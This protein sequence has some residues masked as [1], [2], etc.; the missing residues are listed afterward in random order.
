MNKSQNTKVYKLKY[1]LNFEIEDY[2]ADFVQ[3][4]INQTF[5]IWLGLKYYLLKIWTFANFHNL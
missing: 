2:C 4:I 5:F 3:D 1:L